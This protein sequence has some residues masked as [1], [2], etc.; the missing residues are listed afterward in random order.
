[1]YVAKLGLEAGAVA[2]VTALALMMAV[3]LGGPIT[4]MSKAVV[5][6]GL[7]G[8]WIHLTF[9]LVGGNTYYC[10]SGAACS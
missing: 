5:V 4:T 10:A 9:E 1:M 6:G 7:L 3:W 8:A 2:C